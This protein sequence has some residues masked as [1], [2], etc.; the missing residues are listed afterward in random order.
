MAF[1]GPRPQTRNGESTQ[2]ATN[3]S[4]RNDNKCSRH[5]VKHDNFS[6]FVCKD[7]V[8]LQVFADIDGLTHRL[9]VPF[10]VSSPSKMIFKL[11]CN[12][13]INRGNARLGVRDACACVA[14]TP[15]DCLKLNTPN[16]QFP[17]MQ[18]RL[19][20]TSTTQVC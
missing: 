10:V 4:T 15:H 18:L 5:L 9:G 8:L 2:V 7:K 1:G 13:K 11:C 20:K 16:L 6:K 14:S 3:I 17:C 12:T 19:S